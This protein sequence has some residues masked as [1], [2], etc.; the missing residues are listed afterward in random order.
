VHVYNNYF[1]NNALHGVAST[2]N[3]GVLVEGNY[4]SGVP[5]PCFSTSG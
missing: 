1:L 4:F 3:G 5:Y 2:M